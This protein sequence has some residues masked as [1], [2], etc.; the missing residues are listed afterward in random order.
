MINTI[1]PLISK[2]F[3]YSNSIILR[4]LESDMEFIEQQ[5]FIDIKDEYL[6]NPCSSIYEDL[7]LAFLRN[8]LIRYLHFSIY[9]MQLYYKEQNIN[10]ENKV[11]I[12]YIYKKTLIKI[13]TSI[14][15]ISE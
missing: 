8:Y 15:I 2:N 3:A 1:K 11:K 12:S 14:F 10:T 6:E 13:F 4:V 9:I 7:I 5:P